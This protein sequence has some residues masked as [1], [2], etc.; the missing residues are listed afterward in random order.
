[1]PG[2]LEDTVEVPNLFPQDLSVECE[3]GVSSV[4]YSDR[5]EEAQGAEGT[6]SGDPSLHLSGQQEVTH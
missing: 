6:Q 1:M 2:T 5:T 4:G 3:T